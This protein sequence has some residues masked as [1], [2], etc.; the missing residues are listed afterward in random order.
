MKYEAR[1]AE[2]HGDSWS[3]LVEFPTIYCPADLDLVAE[4]AADMWWSDCAG[5][6]EEF[7]IEV[8]HGGTWHR[9]KVRAE[10]TMTFHGVRISD[11]ERDDNV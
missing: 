2:S 1:D 6:R 7:D 8:K 11:P 10:A 3:D 4:E 9:F 5:E